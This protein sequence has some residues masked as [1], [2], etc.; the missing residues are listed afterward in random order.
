MLSTKRADSL[1]DRTSRL[2]LYGLIIS[3]AAGS[4]QQV[5]LE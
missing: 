4:L 1:L 3:L 5:V 2:D